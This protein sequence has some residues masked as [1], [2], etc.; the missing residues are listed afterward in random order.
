MGI[1]AHGAAETSFSFAFH[2]A[3][4]L[5]VRGGHFATLLMRSARLAFRNTAD[6]VT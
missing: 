2:S 6:D 3:F 5:G 4:F 1:V